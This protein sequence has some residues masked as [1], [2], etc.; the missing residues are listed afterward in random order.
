MKVGARHRPGEV[1]ALHEV[2]PKFG[3]DVELF[4]VLDAFGDG[5]HPKV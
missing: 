3:E 2:A 1:E 5:C 4:A